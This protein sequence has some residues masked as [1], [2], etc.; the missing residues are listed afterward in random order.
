MATL[1]GNLT[2]AV[3]ELGGKSASLV[4]ADAD[5]DQA[6]AAT[7]GFAFSNTGQVCA[8]P[9]RVLVEDAVY[10]AYVAKAQQFV[11]A[12]PIGDPLDPDTYIGPLGH[13]AH[14][15]KVKADIR[16][17]VED[18]A[19]V[20]LWGGESMDLDG[21]FVQPA[22]FGDV[23]PAS[24]L[25]SEEFF[26]PVLSVFRFSSEEQAVEL[27]NSLPYG[28]SAYAWTKD[29]ARGI[30]LGNTLRAGAVNVNKIQNTDP[31][32]PFGGVGISGFGKEGGR[33]GIDEFIHY[34]TVSIAR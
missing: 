10:D 4:F 20:L 24:A 12:L 22:I 9:T 19:G 27:A 16:Q 15:E 23:D 30:R 11:A 17:A 18:E 2:P 25:G 6:V 31:E 3:F 33:V 7:V 5:L 13:G 8:A 21:F 1:S 34:K 26:G 29:L 28:L 32:V 14:Y